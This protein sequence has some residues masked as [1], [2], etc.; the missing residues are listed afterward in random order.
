MLPYR[1]RRRKI[2]KVKT[3]NLKN[4]KKNAFIKI[5]IYQRTRSR[6]VAKFDL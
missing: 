5:E 4:T 1:L 3:Q 2:Q 6:Q